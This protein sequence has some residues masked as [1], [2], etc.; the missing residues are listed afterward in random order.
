MKDFDGIKMHGATI[1]IILNVFVA[2]GIQ[3]AMRMRNIVWSVAC[4]A[5]QYFSRF[6]HKQHDFRKE[7]C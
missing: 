7:Y 6:C 3:Y 4:P 1:K 2:L 5:V